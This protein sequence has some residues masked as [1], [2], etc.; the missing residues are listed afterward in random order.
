MPAGTP[1]LL[2]DP[3]TCRRSCKNVV[4]DFHQPNTGPGRFH[5][6]PWVM[7]QKWHDL[8]FMHWRIPPATLRPLIPSALEL[9]QFE[10][11]A[12]LGVVPFRMTGVRLRATPGIPGLSAFPELNVRTYV[13]KDGKP[14]VWF[15]SLDAASSIAVA[16]A[17]AWFHL[18]YF[19]AR[20]S[21][22][23]SRRRNSLPQPSHASRSPAGR[24][25]RQL[26]AHRQDHATPVPDR[27]NIS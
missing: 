27:S 7:R 14:G 21:L 8:L 5:R 10:G 6:R 3:R 2:S 18:P 26:R 15:F 17:R 12:W 25:A 13:T 23:A 24:S 20:M 9:D 1:A 19:R 4:T 11:S 22:E 16:A